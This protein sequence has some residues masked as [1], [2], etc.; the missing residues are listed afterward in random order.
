MRACPLIWA[1]VL[2]LAGIP[3]HANQTNR[4]PPG[5]KGEARRA[6][7]DRPHGQ[8]LLQRPAPNFWGVG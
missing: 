2:H 7:P 3:V 4:P 1:G 8:A 6:A 5:I